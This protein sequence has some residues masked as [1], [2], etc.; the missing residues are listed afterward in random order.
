MLPLYVQLWQALAVTSQV[1]YVLSCF[2]N[3]YS[4]NSFNIHTIKIYTVFQR[5][6]EV[7]E[8]INDTFLFTNVFT[9]TTSGVPYIHRNK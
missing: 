1:S 3:F 4:D 2:N 8:R 5:E 7:A 9:Y 6:P